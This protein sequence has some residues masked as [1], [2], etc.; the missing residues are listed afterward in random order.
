MCACQGD[1]EICMDVAPL[2]S[3]HRRSDTQSKFCAL[4]EL[5]RWVQRRKPTKPNSDHL[6]TAPGVDDD[7]TEPDVNAPV[8]WHNS[9][10]LH[11][12]QA[13]HSSQR[14]T[15]ASPQRISLLH[16]TSNVPSSSPFSTHGHHVQAHPHPAYLSGPNSRTNLPLLSAPATYD[17]QNIHPSLHP[18]YPPLHPTNPTPSSNFPNLP[19]P[20]ESTRRDFPSA[21]VPPST[22]PRAPGGPAS[23]ASLIHPVDTSPLSRPTSRP[24]SRGYL[25]AEDRHPMPF[26]AER[27]ILR[28]APSSSSAPLIWGRAL[29]E[30]MLEAR[31]V[32]T[33]E[34]IL[35]KALGIH[36]GPLI[37]YKRGVRVEDVHGAGI[38]GVRPVVGYGRAK[39]GVKRRFDT[40]KSERDDTDPSRPSKR[41]KIEV[42]ASLPMVSHRRKRKGQ[43]PIHNSPLAVQMD[44]DQEMNGQF[45]H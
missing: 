15:H 37:N 11:N 20:R 12:Y 10:Q 41:R 25:E 21:S 1:R 24:V 13:T 39:G 14:D 7:R 43:Y 28:D 36:L 2:D 22:T 26:H 18:T 6:P 44:I 9:S 34:D 23:F 38:R 32:Q 45:S 5:H 40:E 3:G 33:D 16:L 30:E 35:S 42:D 8:A 19:I 27:N 29:R 4:M 17:S 31:E